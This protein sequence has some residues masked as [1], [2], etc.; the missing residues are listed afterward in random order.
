MRESYMKHALVPIAE[1]TEE[2]EAVCIIDTL[3][4]A[5]VDVTVASV[6]KLQITASRLVR[7]VADTTIDRCVDKT[8]DLIA[9]PGGTKGAENLAESQ[10]L[11][12]LLR[13]QRQ[14]GRL[15]GAICAAPAVVLLAQGLLEGV[16]ATSHPAFHDRFKPAQL[17]K[18]RVVVAHN[19]VTGQGAG[20]AIDFALVLVELLVGPEKRKEVA[21][22]M[23]VPG[24]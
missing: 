23:V 10:I 12:D 3:R 14:S 5:G 13:Q 21:E 4:R 17:S 24:V 15:L 18:D 2:I 16:K 1:G 9:L 11:K 8:F 19:V 22:A 6:G 7:I 20:V